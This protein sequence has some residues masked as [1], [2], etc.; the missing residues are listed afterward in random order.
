[1]SDGTSTEGQSSSGNEKYVSQID[2]LFALAWN[3]V[4]NPEEAAPAS[5]DGASDSPAGAGEAGAATSSEGAPAGNGDAGA[6]ADGALPTAGDQAGASDS[7]ADTAAGENASAD[8]GTGD[9]GNGTQPNPAGPSS[10]GLDPATVTPLFAPAR[11]EAFKRMETS[12]RQSAIQDLQQE[13][14]PEFLEVLQE[15]PVRLVGS[16][17][18]SLARNADPG[19]K[20]RLNDSAQAAQYQRD[21]SAL[22]ERE[23]TSRAKQKADDTRPMA[24]VI[25]E[26][27]LLFENNPDLIPG[28][29]GFDRELATRFAE[30]TN[31]YAVRVN[32]KVIG[33][34]DINVQP[35]INSLRADIA[36]QRGASGA[37]AAQQRAEQQRQAAAQQ[38]RDEGGKFQA[39][40]GGVLSKAGNQG[41][42]ADDYSAFWSGVQMPNPGSLGI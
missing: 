18:P 4:Y 22:L 14:D 19:A 31:D 39:P 26:S 7:S 12:F 10:E 3:E 16:E 24:T 40:Q 36:K 11:E 2:D 28:T 9:G 17:V 32:G 33:Y 13:I 38:E 27:F 34:Q 37:T 8:A 21:L 6:P 30:I 23:I 20:I 5:E 15:V 42:A 25:Q 29:K 41:E 35:L 1:M